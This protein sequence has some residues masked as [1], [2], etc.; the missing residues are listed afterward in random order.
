MDL[1]ANIGGPALS[2]QIRIKQFVLAN[3]VRNRPSLVEV[4]RELGLTP[5]TLQRRLKAESTT[6]RTVLDQARLEL[7]GRA[8]LQSA[9]TA[10]VAESLGFSEPAAF[11]RA[12][13]R[14]TGTTVRKYLQSHAAPAMA[15]S[16]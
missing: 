1:D 10:R 2:T 16:A 15:Q 9:P 14:W 13:K 3:D 8:L 11:Q 4:A 12:F 5:R 6:Y 7:A